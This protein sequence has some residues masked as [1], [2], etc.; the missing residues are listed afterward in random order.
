MLKN[1]PD[2]LPGLNWADLPPVYSSGLLPAQI[3]VC[4]EPVKAISFSDLVSS[5]KFEKTDLWLGYNEAFHR[6]HDH[7]E[8]PGSL[9]YVV[10]FKGKLLLITQG[11]GKTTDFVERYGGVVGMILHRER[12]RTI[13]LLKDVVREG[14]KQNS[15]SP[16]E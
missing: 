15:Y 10:H 12:T 5:E 14:A 4:V 13:S 6:L 8:S 11:T 3:V 2:G 16:S 1:M 9:A 7:L